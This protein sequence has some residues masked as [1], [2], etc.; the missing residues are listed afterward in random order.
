IRPG[1]G[2]RGRARRRHRVL[3]RPMSPALSPWRRRSVASWEQTPSACA[4]TSGNSLDCA[5]AVV[6]NEQNVTRAGTTTGGDGAS[7]PRG[8]C[9]LDLISR[10]VIATTRRATHAQKDVLP[11]GSHGCGLGGPLGLLGGLGR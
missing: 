7:R 2:N 3:H 1:N 11:A 9:R 10:G 4:A 6:L 5:V 8:C